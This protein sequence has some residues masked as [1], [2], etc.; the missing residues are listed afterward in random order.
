[1]SYGTMNCMGKVNMENLF[2]VSHNVGSVFF[3][4]VKF[5]GL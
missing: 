1:M 2:I 5:L 3:S 4:I